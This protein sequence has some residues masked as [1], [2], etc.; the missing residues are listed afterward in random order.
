M[1]VF[2]CTTSTNV[3]L[4]PT[5]QRIYK[6]ETDRYHFFETEIGHLLSL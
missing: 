5:A 3:L 1:E 4:V 2:Q 6:L